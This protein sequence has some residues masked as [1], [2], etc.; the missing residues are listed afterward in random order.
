MGLLVSGRKADVAALL[1]C[2]RNRVRGFF[3]LI[4]AQIRANDLLFFFVLLMFIMIGNS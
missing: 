3:G 1:V 2:G 4:L